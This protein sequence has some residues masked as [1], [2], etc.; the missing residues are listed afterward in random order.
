V[1]LATPG[2]ELSSPSNIFLNQSS[3]A[4]ATVAITDLNGF[5]DSVKLGLSALPRGVTASIEPE[6]GNKQKV[7]FKA[8]ALADT[9]LTSVTLTG[10]S[11]K[12]K[13]TAT[14]T[15]AVN[16]AL[17]TAGAGTEV[18]LSANFN[19]FGI[20]KDG[21][22]YSTGGLDGV[23]FS[24]SANLLT[25]SR[26]LDLIRFKYG[27]SN[28]L[29]AVG[30]DG[31][32]ISLPQGQYFGLLLLGTGV[33]GSQTSQHITVHYS[34]GTSSQFTQNFSDWF[35]PQN[36]PGEFGAVAMSHRNFADG[37]EDARIFNLYAYEFGLDSTKTVESVTLP[38]NRDVVILA[39]TLV[40]VDAQ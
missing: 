21:S 9:G 4:T 33:E 12:I 11:G 34:D 27:P 25:P 1:T 24:Y 2:F 15:L 16:A 28:E 13:Q 14:F 35:S 31:E 36:F 29:D 19:V 38:K 6:K 40:G 18:D 37:S 22:A 20:Y 39:A 26:V 30:C 7:V 3:T 23:G 10:K 5:T 17:G 32:T 8:T